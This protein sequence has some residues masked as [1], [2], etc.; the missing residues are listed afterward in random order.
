MKNWLPCILLL[1]LYACKEKKSDLSGDTPIKAADFIAAF[2]KLTSNF[3]VSDT[4]I[5]SKSDTTVIGLKALTQFIPDS[6]LSMLPGKDKKIV[7]HPV[8]LI[9]KEKE[10]Y[11]LVNFERRNKSRLAV[12][13]FDKKTK[14]LGGKELL[15]ND[16][17]DGYIHSVSIN[18]EP[19]FI[20]SKEKMG[21]D[22]VIQFSRTGWVYNNA[23]IFMVVIN[24]SNEGNRKSTVINPIDTLPRKNK[25]S[26][27]YMQ[28]KKNYVSV[29]DGKNVNTYLFFVHFEK[30]DG[31]CIGELKGQLKLT[32]ANTG[33]FTANG[34]PCVIDFVFE[35]NMLKIK[36]GGSC[37]NHRG[38]K[39]FFDDSFRKKKEV[40]SMKKNKA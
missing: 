29:R 27:D 31:S 4:N 22:N 16:T 8:G 12:F 39:C 32:G 5:V 26:G 36:E 35:G 10:N 21:K 1:C 20:I 40:R 28:D 33:Q 11:L 38:I 18:R 2:P 13:V 9:E 15:S 7:I 25:H 19:T 14:F 6:A 23:G 17:N 24:D 37:G 30:N 3:T 34:D